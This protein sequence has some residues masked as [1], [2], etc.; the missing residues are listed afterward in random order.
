M[1]DS[2]RDIAGVG[3]HCALRVAVRG[4][5][6][7]HVRGPADGAVLRLNAVQSG[8]PV[9]R[10]L[11]DDG[12][13]AIAKRPAGGTYRVKCSSRSRCGQSLGARSRRDC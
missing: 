4:L 9:P 10:L 12:L 13:F 5:P 6:H 7:S 1:D 11:Q 2:P 8:E 3:S